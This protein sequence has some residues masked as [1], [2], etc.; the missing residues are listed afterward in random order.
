VVPELSIARVFQRELDALPLPPEDAWIPNARP[1]HAPVLAMALGAV[2]LAA[3]LIVTVYGV[4]ASQD[5]A[6]V[7]TGAVSPTPPS[8]PCAGSGAHRP[9]LAPLPVIYRSPLLGYNIVVPGGF[10]RVANDA[11]ASRTSSGL[12]YR[13]RFTVRPADEDRATLSNFGA[14][15]PWDFVVEVYE[16][17]VVSASERALL[18][19]CSAGCVT[20]QT[21]IRKEPT[22]SATWTVGGLV[23]HGYY[24][25]RGDRVLVLKYAVGPEMSRPAGVNESDLLRIVE[26]IGLV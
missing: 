2:A 19:G 1:A 14:I 17:A 22:L 24:M 12:V 7:G 18:D 15:P 20:T 13:E 10:H 9:C 23:M 16:R 25:D 4:R 5:P 8:S 26:T 6:A 21:T 11:P 3:I